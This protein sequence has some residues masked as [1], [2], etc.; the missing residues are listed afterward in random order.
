LDAPGNRSETMVLKLG[1]SGQQIRNDGAETWTLRETR[2]YKTNIFLR[3]ISSWRQRIMPKL[4]A[5]FMWME[6]LALANLIFITEETC[7]LRGTDW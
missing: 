1:R 5:G 7:S 3:T 4:V 2:K 6:N